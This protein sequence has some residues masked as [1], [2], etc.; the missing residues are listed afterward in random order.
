MSA[1]TAR[2]LKKFSSFVLCFSVIASTMSTAVADPGQ[3]LKEKYRDDLENVEQVKVTDE[4]VYRDYRNDAL[5]SGV[6]DYDGEDII[7]PIVPVSFEGE[8]EPKIVTDEEGTYIET[9]EESEFVTFSVNVPKTALYQMDVT[10][11][12]LEGSGT[13]IQRAIHINGKVPFDEAFN[14]AFNRRWVDDGEPKRN[15]LGDEVRQKQKEVFVFTKTPLYDSQGYYEEPLTFLLNEGLNTIT[16]EVVDEPMA[17]RE[18]VLRKPEEF[19]PYSEVLEEYKRNGYKE[20]SE[21]TLY[22]AEIAA[23]YKSDPVLR[24]SSDSD[25]KTQPRERHIKKLNMIGG[26]SWRTGGQEIIF[27]FDIKED[28]LYQ[29]SMR[30]QQSWNDG[31]PSYR[32][33][34]IDGKVPFAEMNTVK[35]HYERGWRMDTISDDEGNP[36]LFYLTKGRHEI[37]MRVVMG[38]LTDVIFGVME[39]TI[40]LSEWYRKIIL[41][42]STNPDVNFEYKLDK[43]IPGLIDGFKALSED[44]KEMGDII[45]SISVKVPSMANNFYTI[46]DQLRDMA[47][48]PDTISR[49]LDDLNNAQRNLGT[50]I[51]E[52]KTRPL[53]IDYFI[54]GPTGQKLPKAKSGFWE[55]SVVTW[56]NF[57]RSF[58]VDY[59]NITTFTDAEVNEVIDVWIGRGKDWAQLV[60]QLADEDFTPKTGIRIN[61]NI[62]PSGQLSAGS[63][64]AL[65]LA[66][67]SGRAPDVA[68]GVDVTSP[69]EFAIRNAA[70]DLRQFEDF[71]E[72]AKRFNKTILTPFEYKGGVFALPDQ[73]DFQVLMYRKDILSELGVPLPKTWN[74]VYEK[75]LPILYENQLEFLPAGFNVFLYQLGGSY[76]RDNGKKS[77]LD[78]AEAYQAFKMWTDQYVSYGMPVQSDF[79]NRFRN[80]EMP[81][82][83]VGYSDYIKMTTAA[84][85][86]FGRWDI[87]YIPGMLKENGEIDR[88]FGPI[89]GLTTMI[90]GQS[91]KKEAAW[92]FLKWWTSEETQT[93]FGRELESLLGIEARWNSANVAAF[94]NSAWDKKHKDIILDQLKWAKE[95]PNVLGGYFTSRHV[96]NAWTRVVTGGQNPRDSLEQAVKDIN[97]ELRSK[98][99]E[100]GEYVEDEE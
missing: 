19:R 97:K 79:F 64:N 34:K 76:Y 16:F 62:L 93:Q 20:V 66:V 94:E 32:Q 96:N 36:Y 1:Y 53:A 14:I 75:V 24:R 21:S 81:M 5:A 42:T 46:S 98:Q 4:K 90:M 30:D 45:T 23:I 51:N 47:R 10:Y 43:T 28:G 11:M 77:N 29:I 48:K 57:L 26:W 33:I 86:L 12:P 7:V 71:D 56:D 91:K 50:Y 2:F 83:I 88:S 61:M 17:I 78:T 49:K 70:T 13:V 54:F 15:T 63:V 22:E 31:L 37:S 3:M 73:M 65:M 8:M 68:S 69:V 35:F 41:I 25:P 44:L 74:D 82:G 92:E 39:K 89:A 6:K 67:T 87:T 95:M 38:P 52:L 85:E 18:I 60:Q 55:K 27:E 9:Y 84:P 59:D 40:E 58:T 99:E 80:G 72:V 100:Y